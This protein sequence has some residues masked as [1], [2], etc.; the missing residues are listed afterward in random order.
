[1]SEL[2]P[3]LRMT[4]V[5]KR[6]GNVQALRSVDLEV[7][8]NEVHGLLGGNGA[9]KTTLMNVLYGLYR[10][11]AGTIEID[12]SGVEIESPRD[13]IEAGVGM[14]HQTFLQI[15]TYTVTENIVLG[16]EDLGGLRL[17]LGAARERIVQLSERFGLAVD[18]EAVV[19]D[20][21]VGVR[22]RVEILKALYRGSKIL[23]LD[24]PTTNLTPQE[25]DDLF[26]SIRA[27]VD[28]GMSVILITHK[29][30]ETMSVCDRMTV[31]R[32]GAYIATVDKADTDPEQLASIM[33]GEQVVAE[34]SEHDPGDNALVT[35]GLL[36]ERELVAEHAPVPS[37][38]AGDGG[39][40]EATGLVIANDHG[41]DLFQGFDL[42]V[43]PGE[44]VGIAGVA[45][46]G[47]VELAEAVSGVRRLRAGSVRLDGRDLAGE[48]T[49]G[50]LSAGVA[51]V[52]EDRHRD[53]ILPT[54]SITENLLLGSHRSSAVKRR[55][56]IDWRLA[57]Q[58][59][60]EMIEKFSVR[61]SGPS[62]AAGDLSG[63]NIQR[64][65]LARAFAREPRLLVL[66]NPTRGL[67]IGST[68]F[69][70]EQVRAATS[71]GCAVLLLS[72]DL[73]EVIALSDRIIALYA[74]RSTGEWA[75]AE[76][77]RYDIG[78]SMTGLVRTHD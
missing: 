20:L 72:E 15:D 69:V 70:Y 75:R 74:G 68:Q 2:S 45:G 30:R 38:P 35:T 51:Y 49:A 16:T 22:Q 21:P 63:G 46:N 33:V 77:D 6:F 54:R 10:P 50:W 59:A 65:I 13:A 48:P 60:V 64:V 39:G 11:D 25:V 28:E 36:D 12:G 14:V 71:A 19:E 66:H 61:A 47:Q 26:G 43:A 73:D 41:V 55:G 8:R 29:I 9:G 57:R 7:A 78:R 1:M 3:R 52:P 4:G 5:Q 62:A 17:D 44:V 76:A 40:V 56:L 58:N 24:E 32:N 34:L 18:P 42:T 31:M 23:I 67:D 27:M 53:G 37:A